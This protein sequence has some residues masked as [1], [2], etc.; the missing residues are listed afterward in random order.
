MLKLIFYHSPKGQKDTICL[1]LLVL[2]GNDLY[3]RG[4]LYVMLMVFSG[5]VM[6]AEIPA[7]NRTR[8]SGSQSENE[9]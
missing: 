1:F 8:I 6:I 5:M 9:I 3:Y 7:Q 2:P 4:N